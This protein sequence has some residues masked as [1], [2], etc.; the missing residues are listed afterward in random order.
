MRCVPD[1]AEWFCVRYKNHG[2]IEEYLGDTQPYWVECV[3][4]RCAQWL[5]GSASLDWAYENWIVALVR[6]TGP[7]FRAGYFLTAVYIVIVS[8]FVLETPLLLQYDLHHPQEDMR[9]GNVTLV[10]AFYLWTLD[11]G[12]LTLSHYFVRHYGTPSRPGENGECTPFFR[13]PTRQLRE[14]REKQ[15]DTAY[16]ATVRGAFAVFFTL[17]FVLGVFATHTI[18]SHMFVK[19]NVYFAWLLGIKVVMVVMASV[20]DLTCIGSPWGIQECSKTASVLLSF[21]ALF[22]V[23]LTVIWSA[24]AVA[25]SFPPSYC[26]EC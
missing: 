5:N 19:R 16:R 14:V 10:V 17:H 22:L 2:R 15:P 1:D 18:L 9:F 3:A 20:D 26:R 24:A 25:A 6:E 7:G 13:V 21:R 12:L 4:V 11:F 8:S 23:P